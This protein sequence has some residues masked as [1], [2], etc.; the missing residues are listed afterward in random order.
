MIPLVSS[1]LRLWPVSVDLE[2]VCLGEAPALSPD[3]AQRV[4]AIWDRAVARRQETLFDGH[5]LSLEEWTPQR[6]TVRRAPYRLFWAGRQ[7]PTLRSALG[8]RPLAVSGLVWSHGHLIWGRRGDR[9]TQE[10]GRWELAPSGGLDGQGASLGNGVDF[11]AQLWTEAHEELGI[12]AGELSHPRPLV[13]VEDVASQVWDLGLE[14]VCC[15]TPDQV[16]IRHQSQGSSEYQRLDLVPA[17][18]LPAFLAAK[19]DELVE[20]SVALCQARGLAGGRDV[21]CQLT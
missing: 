13:L 11:G 7:E 9:V 18:A 6:L 2:V 1:R 14:C 20:V 17:R 19:R 3:L 21:E 15:L 8:I 10:A 4:D 5:L 12:Q 16:L